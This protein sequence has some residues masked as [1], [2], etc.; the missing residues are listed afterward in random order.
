[1]PIGPHSSIIAAAF[2]LGG[3]PFSAQ[4]PV[5]LNL[6]PS[7]ILAES[8]AVDGTAAPVSLLAKS[9]GGSARA[10][11][12]A[13][14]GPKPPE[15]MVSYSPGKSRARIELGALGAG[16]VDAPGLVHL[17]LGVNF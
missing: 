17:D 13:P 9:S 6:T 14:I 16:R 1:M 15:L 4:V 2:L 12:L 5:W 10:V 8:A 3:V 7:E 11:L